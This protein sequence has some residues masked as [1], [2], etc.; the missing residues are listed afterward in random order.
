MSPFT[1]QHGVDV[2]LG[3]VQAQQKVADERV[4]GLHAAFEQQAAALRRQSSNAAAAQTSSFATFLATAL[5]AAAARSQAA[6]CEDKLDVHQSLPEALQALAVSFA[7]SAE[8]A[9][10]TGTTAEKASAIVAALQ[11]R[12][13]VADKCSTADSNVDHQEQQAAERVDEELRAALRKQQDA[14]L[15]E[16]SAMQQQLQQLTIERDALKAAQ[17]NSSATAPGTSEMVW[18]HNNFSDRG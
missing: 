3:H 2:W 10:A 4:A 9:A 8:P 12:R 5:T 13:G 11:C 1:N 6:H 7:A 18:L 16:R 17:A 14:S 15:Q